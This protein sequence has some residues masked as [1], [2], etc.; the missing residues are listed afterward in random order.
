MAD[1]R[2]VD[3]SLF[4]SPADDAL[5][6]HLNTDL[7]AQRI[8]EML[9]MLVEELPSLAADD[10][11]GWARATKARRKATY[12]RSKLPQA[13]DCLQLMLAALEQGK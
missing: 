11:L 2:K 9:A 13:I 5:A 3:F 6:E 1:S 12:Y 7:T 10:G 4:R 8:D